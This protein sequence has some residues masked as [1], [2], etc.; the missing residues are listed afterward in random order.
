[1]VA[2]IVVV[3]APAIASEPVATEVGLEAAALA[4]ATDEYA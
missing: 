4:S 2:A 1:M 3:A